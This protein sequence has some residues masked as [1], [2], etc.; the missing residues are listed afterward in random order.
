MHRSG[1]CWFSTGAPDFPCSRLVSAPLS[2][3][4]A[5]LEVA[6]EKIWGFHRPDAWYRRCLR[7]RQ[8]LAAGCGCDSKPTSS[9]S[10]QASICW[11]ST[12]W[13]IGCS[14]NQP[15]A[16]A[17]GTG[18]GGGNVDN[19]ALDVYFEAPLCGFL[20]AC[21]RG[22]HELLTSWGSLYPRFD[23]MDSVVPGGRRR[24]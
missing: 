12:A 7:S 6:T 8:F 18:Q 10:G 16:C 9:L 21:D 13:R 1:R 4:G 24:D 15:F 11:W 23:A 22:H 19:Q 5:A 20:R 3:G 17:R 14:C 2:F